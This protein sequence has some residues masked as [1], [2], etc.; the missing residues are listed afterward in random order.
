MN[1]VS[2]RF[3]WPR[4]W[5]GLTLLGII[6]SISPVPVF[7]QEPHPPIDRGIQLLNEKKPDEALPL[8][9]QAAEESPRDPLP[10]YYIGLIYKEKRDFS[11]ALRSFQEALRRDP[12]MAP[13]ALRMGETLEAGGRYAAARNTYWK[14]LR[15][16]EGLD[17]R[18]AEAA[19]AGTR[20][21][22]ARELFLLA[23]DPVR[24][25]RYEEAVSLL[26]TAQSLDRDNVALHN[27][28]GNIYLLAQ[29]PDLA[30]ETYRRILELTPADLEATYRLGAL[31]Q[32]MGRSKE[33]KETFQKVLEMGPETPQAAQVRE[34]LPLVEQSIALQV[35]FEAANRHIEKEEWKEAR[36]EIEAV[37][38]LEPENGLALYLMGRIENHLEEREK[39]LE[40]LKRSLEIA[41]RAAAW[42][43][44][45]IVLEGL[46][47]HSEALEA[48]QTVLTL[49]NV[50]EEARDNAKKR[51]EF[52]R[53]A[54]EAGSAAEEVSG[55]I[56]KADIAGAIQEA[57]RILALRPDDG[58]G[59]KILAGLYFQANRLDEAVAALERGSEL[60]PK[61]AEIFSILA[62]AYEKLEQ[63]DRAAS[64]YERVAALEPESPL[65]REAVRRSKEVRAVGSRRGVLPEGHP[66]GPGFERGE[67][68]RG[69][70]RR[71][72]RGGRGPG[73]DGDEYDP[74]RGREVG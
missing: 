50:P 53:S 42:M 11:K 29:R 36:P 21:A 48:Y 9:Q 58:K 64:S 35:R 3:P 33:A 54:A 24:E 14:V 30:I 15:I 73:F 60:D 2:N 68:R 72:E 32:N 26:R 63:Y 7:S 38:R 46:S 47:R 10:H 18:D 61:D 16:P 40:F 34:R 49:E 62:A 59:Y 39:A 57:E 23:V 41:P 27:S 52:L 17:P 5:V 44:M 51:I 56:E 55:L 19:L 20:R 37:L 69:A 74:F 70:S 67:D 71:I 13:A 4:R 45:G 28:A 66:I 31:Y 8:F 6:F 43:E 12:L 22:T 1:G 65:G 25:K